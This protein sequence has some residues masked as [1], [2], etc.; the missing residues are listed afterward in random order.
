MSSISQDLGRH[1][2]GLTPALGDRNIPAS[3]GWLK[4]AESKTIKLVENHLREHL[5]NLPLS[6]GL[7]SK[8]QVVKGKRVHWASFNL[9]ILVLWTSL[10]EDEHEVKPEGTV[11]T[12]HTPDKD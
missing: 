4:K 12:N 5:Q 9:E 6:K 8:P 1:G 3:L 10:L 11:F 7:T 2:T